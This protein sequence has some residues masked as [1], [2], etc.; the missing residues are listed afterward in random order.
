[1]IC[2]YQNHPKSHA[3]YPFSG[4]IAIIPEPELRAFWVDWRNSPHA[5]VR[6]PAM[7][8]LSRIPHDFCQWWFRQNADKSSKLPEFFLLSKKQRIKFKVA[9]DLN[10]RNI[11]N[12]KH[13]TKSQISSAAAHFQWG[14]YKK[15]YFTFS[16]CRESILTFLL[17][18]LHPPVSERCGDMGSE[19]CMIQKLAKLYIYDI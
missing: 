2:I 10:W 8:K 18:L 3:S 9:P 15:T 19:I 14:F 17:S 4:E 12:H 6:C 13:W 7:R 16:G 5:I 11:T 1:M